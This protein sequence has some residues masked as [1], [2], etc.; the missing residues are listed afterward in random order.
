MVVLLLFNWFEL[1]GGGEIGD[2]FSIWFVEG[3]YQGIEIA[4]GRVKC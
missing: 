4:E 3:G 1:R 2:C